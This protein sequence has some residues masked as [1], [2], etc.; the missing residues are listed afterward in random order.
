MSNLRRE[1]FDIKLNKDG[2]V[3]APFVFKPE[4]AALGAIIATEPGVLPTM[5]G[6]AE[7][8]WYSGNMKL[9]QLTIK[10]HTPSSGGVFSDGILKITHDIVASQRRTGAREDALLAMRVGL[11]CLDRNAWEIHKFKKSEVEQDCPPGVD[12]YPTMEE[13]MAVWERNHPNTYMIEND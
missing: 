13:W 8:C 6:F 9:N 2:T 5:G 10:L 11:F 3:K 1:R 12:L 7:N 4:M